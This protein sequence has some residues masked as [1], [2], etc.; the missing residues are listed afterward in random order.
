M[1][2]ASRVDYEATEQVAVISLNRAPVN[3]ID[4]P[5]IDAIHA[6]C[7]RRRPTATCAPSS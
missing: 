2:S 5:M 1:S 6:A 7:A 3:A 4:H